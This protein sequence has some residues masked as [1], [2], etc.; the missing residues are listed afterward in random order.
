VS[1]ESTE[2]QV[3]VRGLGGGRQAPALDP[4]TAM[5]LG[6]GVA[7]R[8]CGSSDF[9]FRMGRTP[10][11]VAGRRSRN[12]AADGDPVVNREVA[13]SLASLTEGRDNS[14]DGVLSNVFFEGSRLSAHRQERRLESAGR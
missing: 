6:L 9:G 13:R 12:C 5:D 10:V 1:A 4:S 2:E 8:C 3:V 11:D 7:F 14:G